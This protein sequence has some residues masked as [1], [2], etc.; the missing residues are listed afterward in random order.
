[1]IH[2]Q[3]HLIGNHAYN[4]PD[5]ARMS[6]TEI[7]EQIVQTNEIIE[8][9]IG[10]QPKWFAPPSGSFNDS[11]IQI[12]HELDMETVLWTV[13]TIDW[14]KPSVSVMINRV[15]NNIHPGATILMHPTTSVAQGLEQLIVE[16]KEQDL[17]LH[18]IEELLKETR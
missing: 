2:E 18:T 4:H 6:P 14:K 13:D 15:I 16:I 10:I 17:K 8:A 12:A 7:K 3:N 11:V 1:M 9:I 5:M